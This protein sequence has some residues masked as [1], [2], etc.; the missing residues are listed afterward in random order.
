MKYSYDPRTGFSFNVIDSPAFYRVLIREDSSILIIGFNSFCHDLKINFD[1]LDK[2]NIVLRKEESSS[3]RGK[4]DYRLSYIL[5]AESSTTNV[6]DYFLNLY[7]LL[8]KFNILSLKDNP[9][10]NVKKI[11]F[12]D[13]DYLIYKP[14]TLVF[15]NENREFMKSL[16]KNGKDLDRNWVKFND[17]IDVGYF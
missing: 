5:T 2:S 6:V 13:H 17:T 3:E 10:V 7:R 4:Y 12:S 15:W 1:S 8:D 16:F 9:S 14:D 11:I